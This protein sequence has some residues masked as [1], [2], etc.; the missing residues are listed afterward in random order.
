MSRA[1]E[2]V[3]NCKI[4]AGNV[5]FT[6]RDAPYSYEIRRVGDN[7]LYRVTGAGETMEAPLLYAFGQGKAGQ[8]YVFQVDGQF[9]ESRVSYYAK[10]G[11][12]DLT[13][14]AMNASPSSLLVAAGRVMS[15]NEPRNCFGCHTTGARVGGTL[16]LAH[17]ETG[18]QCESCHGPGAAHVA[19]A[20]SGKALAGTIRPLKAMAPQESGEFCGACHRTWETV[21]LMGIKGIN[22]ARFPAYRL[23]N[24]ACFSLD[25][26]RISCTVCHDPHGALVEDDRYYDSK[27]AACHNKGNAALKKQLCPVGK[28]RCTS[29]HMQR[30]EPA[31]AHHAFPDHWIRVVRSKSDYPN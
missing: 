25:D 21:M 15:G 19:A 17:F 5:H 7:V 18:V 16:Q 8:T 30:V 22:N 14:G 26:A 20:T 10:L 4:L 29:C 2:P 1:L 3:S 24:S 23:A 27:C 12:L 6:F 28:E 31:E 11:G 13:V 9:Y